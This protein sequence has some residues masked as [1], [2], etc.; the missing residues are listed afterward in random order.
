MPHWNPPVFG[1]SAILAALVS[2]G[3]V[4][5]QA[6]TPCD[7]LAASPFDQSRPGG[8][9]GVGSDDIDVDAALPACTAEQAA[10]PQDARLAFQ[11]G[12]VKLAANDIDAA[13][14]LFQQS[15]AAGHALA[16]V[17]LG[18]VMENTAPEQARGWYRKAADQGAMLGQYNLAV[19]YHKGIGGAVDV[20]KALDYYAQAM[21]QGDAV[22]AF[23]MAT[24]HDEGLLK[25]R[26]VAQA[27][28]LYQVAADRGNVDAMVNLAYMTE[29]GDG[30]PA[31][32]TAALHL[33]EKAASLGDTDAA[34]EVA[35]LSSAP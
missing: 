30:L 15:A 23:N 25:P 24:I 8:V 28:A 1:L 32:K 7:Q 18:A 22:S 2:F 9:A 26:D 14:A 31:D 5:A 17:N 27:V 4:T 35:R 19:A 21:A 11:L 33:F 3:A 34:A 12:R 20:D 16:M 6:E 29:S 13:T 10:A